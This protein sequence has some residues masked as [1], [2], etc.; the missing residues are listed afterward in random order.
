VQQDRQELEARDHLT[1]G[2]AIVAQLVEQYPARAE[3]K[4][5]LAWFDKQIKALGP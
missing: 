4:L 3:W 2:R 1:A 5:G